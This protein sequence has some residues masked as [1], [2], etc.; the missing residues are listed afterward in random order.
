[1]FEFLKS[2]FLYRDYLIQSVMR[3][4]RKRYKRS[5]LGYLWSMLNPLLMMIVLTV[6]F[7]K[8]MRS[9]DIDHYAIFL[10]AGMIPWT[11]FSSTVLA[12]LHAIKGNIQIISQ[13]PVPKYLFVL[14]LAFSNMYTF[15]ISLVPLILISLFMGHPITWHFLLFPICFIPLFFITMGVSL[16]LAAL[17]VFFEDTEHLTGVVIQAM[18]F[19]CP[20]LYP[21]T[22][23]PPEVVTILEF[24]PMFSMTIIF[25][26][27]FYNNQ[28]PEMHNIIYTLVSSVL[29]L[30]AGLVIFNKADKRMIYFT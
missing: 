5:I 17:N 24:N 22:M 7:S 8:M 30:I 28:I 23:L 10:F 16:C 13:I 19:L 3:D 20:I 21:M 18:Y 4:L 26:D 27:I 9:E 12:S 11:Y 14:S 15:V 6:V 1:M 25:K 29:V 2:I